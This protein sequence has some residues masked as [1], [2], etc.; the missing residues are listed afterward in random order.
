MMADNFLTVVPLI[1]PLF[2]SYRNA[3]ELAEKSKQ[4]LAESGMF[5]EPIVTE[6]RPAAP[7]MKL[8]NTTSISIKRT[9]R[10]M[11]LSKKNLAVKT[12]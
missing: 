5:K 1:A 9:Q 10:N 8:R 7:F 3:K 2:L 4:A 6:I 12:L 11:L